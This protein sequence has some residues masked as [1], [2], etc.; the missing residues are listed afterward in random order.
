MTKNKPSRYGIHT[1]RFS[2]KVFK[3]YG[4][5]GWFASK[6]NAD[7]LAKKEREWGAEAR[8]VKVEGG[9]RLFLRDKPGSRGRRRR[10]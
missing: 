3:S 4:G 8:V 7:S 6:D 1:R 9:Y 10:K 5:G 2:G